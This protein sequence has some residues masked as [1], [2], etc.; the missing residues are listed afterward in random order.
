MPRRSLVRPEL[1]EHA[2][3]LLERLCERFPLG[4]VPAVK[5]RMLRVSAGLAHFREGAIS[6]SVEILTDEERLTDTLL[7]EYAHLLAFARHG[8]AGKGHGPAW[9]QA[10]ADLGLPPIVRHRYAVRRNGARQTVHYVCARCGIRF[11]RRRR[12]PRGRQYRHAACGG[13]IVLAGVE[14]RDALESA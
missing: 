6:L 9:R 12:F 14:A 10:M 11:E 13:A 2:E 1:L 8:E 7:H 4:Y 5:W 3:A